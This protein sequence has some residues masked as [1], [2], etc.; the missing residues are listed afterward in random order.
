MDIGRLLVAKGLISAQD[1][2]RAHQHQRSHGGR[3]V[4]SI[5]A[6][7]LMTQEQIDEVLTDAPQAPAR[8]QDSGIDGVF[9][10]ELMIK[11]MY[12]ESLE[13]ASQLVTSLKLTNTIITQLVQLATERKLVE[14]LSSSAGSGL[15]A[16]LRYGL[17]R[18]GREYAID[19][20]SR[21]QYFGP[22]PVSLT[23]YQD[24]IV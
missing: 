22:A 24:R 10:L 7:G 4:D 2:D 17:T 21:S 6:L 1:I 16:E 11:G 3:L 20:L 14:A 23:D 5:I 15:R 13:T 18:A 9:L 19:A 8:I 12:A